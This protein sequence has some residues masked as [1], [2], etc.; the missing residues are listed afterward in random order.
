MTYYIKFDFEGFSCDLTYK[1]F[2]LLGQPGDSWAY[3]TQDKQVFSRLIVNSPW[4]IVTV[5][6]TMHD[7]TTSVKGQGYGD[8]FLSVYPLRK[9]SPYVYSIRTFSTEDTNPEDRWFFWIG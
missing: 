3:M 2:Y 4:A 6:I 1:I 9:I 5:T 7:K 8:R